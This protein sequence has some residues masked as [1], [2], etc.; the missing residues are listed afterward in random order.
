MHDKFLSSKSHTTL[1]G[2]IHKQLV[3]SGVKC[4]VGQIQS[5][6]RNLKRS[7]HSTVDHNSQTG[8]E[9][10]KSKF[11][12]EFSELYGTKASTIPPAT[13]E[14]GTSDVQS[15]T[16]SIQN[17]DSEHGEDTDTMGTATGEAKKKIKQKKREST[18]EKVLTLLTD[19][20]AK[21]LQ[22]MQTMHEDRMQRMDRLLDILA[23]K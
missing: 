11:Y 4:T 14:L 19:Q 1:W 9:A 10:K 20:S 17:S 6:W 2:R 23:S 7:Y 21:Q 8:V 16:T 5:K 15:D 12:D 22:Q 13:L 3:E 18:G